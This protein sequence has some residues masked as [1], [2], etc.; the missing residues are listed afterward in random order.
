MT[1][2]RV[3]EMPRA[4]AAAPGLARRAE[5]HL[6]R[7]RRDRRHRDL[8]PRAD[9]G[10]AG[11]GARAAAHGVREPGD[12]G[13]RRTGPGASSIPAVTVP[14]R[15]RNR[16]EWVRG[17]QVLLPGA[18]GRRRRGP[19]A[20]P[21]VDRARPAG[22]FRRVTTV[23]DLHYRT[24]PEAHFGLLGLG[25]RMLVP[26]AARRSHRVL[27]DS[28]AVQRRARRPARGCRTERIDVVPLGTGQ[29]PAGGA[30]PGGGGAPP[31]RRSATGRSCSPSPRSGRTRT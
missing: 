21:R 10:A 17:E 24:V 31:A 5:P 9:P 7:A 13:G 28:R 20:Q 19:P 27:T 16:V 22:R 2:H 12:R 1:G 4:G 18:R 14:V 23:H 25:M 8:R 15:A 30:A 6:P 11:G 3:S 29:A 26:L